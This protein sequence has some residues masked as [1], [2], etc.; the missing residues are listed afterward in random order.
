MLGLLINAI[1]IIFVLGFL[2]T[3]HEGGHFLIA[4]LCKVKVNDFSIGFGPIIWKKQGKETKYTLRLIPLGGFVN[5]EGEEERSEKEGSFSKAPIPKRIAIV[6]AGGGVNIIF[7]VIVYFVLSGINGNFVTTT[8]DSTVS[9]YGSQISGIQ[10]GDEIVK[11][12]NKAI[13]LKYDIDS[14]MKANSGETLSIDVKRNNEIL[15]Y[16]VVPTEEKTNNIGIYFGN[17]N[18]NLSTAI[19][20]VY[21]DSPA[22]NFIKKG[23]IVKSINNI[24]VQDNPYKVVELINNSAEVINISV[25][26]DGQELNFNIEPTV[27]STYYL[28]V[29]MKE[30]DKSL[31]NNIYYAFWD[32]ANFSTS[33]I[34]NLKMLFQG[35]VSV[36]QMMGPIGISEMVADTDGAYEFIYLLALISLSLGVTNLLPFPPLDGGKVVLLIIEAIRRKPLKENFEIGLQTAGFLVLITLSIYISYNDVVRIFIK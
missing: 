24:D 4:K 5:L 14:I 15:N 31:L 17:E 22:S 28:G 30:A 23:D 26:R 36:D 21:P 8:V 33:I 11:I 27:T 25:I 16:Q 34:E 29:I 1:K 7:G 35:N 9:G 10:S 20:Y 18:E 12:N 3:I 32:T 19:K 2:I 13:H 6:L